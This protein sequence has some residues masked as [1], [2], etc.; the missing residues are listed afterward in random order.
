MHTMLAD[1][2]RTTDATYR[3]SIEK[4]REAL[5]AAD[6]VIVG[7]GAGLSTAAGYAY[8]GERFHAHFADRRA[9]RYPRYVFGRIL[10]LSHAAGVLGIL[11]PY[12]LA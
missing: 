10:P 2:M 5:N 4:L 8:G 1:A 7:A 6:A 9:V 11:E 3:E 12:D